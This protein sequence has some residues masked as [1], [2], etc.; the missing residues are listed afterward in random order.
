MNASEVLVSVLMTAYNREKYI[1]EAIL[2]V[3]NSTYANFELIIL[4]DCSIDRT[5][6]I[7]QEYQTRDPRI[8]VYSNQQNLGDYPN[9]NKA[10]SYAKG[11][12]IMFVDSDDSIHMK[13]IEYIVKAFEKYPSAQHST[14]YYEKDIFEVCL[15]NPKEA[16]TRH[17]YTNNMLAGGPGAKVFKKTFYSSMGGYPEQYGPANDMYFNIKTTSN[18]AILLLPFIYLNY[19]IHDAQESN[20]RLSYLVNGYNYFVDALKLPELP[21]NDKEKNYFNLKSKRRFLVNSLKYYFST[22]RFNKLRIAFKLTRFT[23][24]DFIKAVFQ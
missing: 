7:A 14:I 23:F 13:A 4:D 18:S 5:L 8:K 16:I 12:L 22:F 6:E 9:R 24:N 21:L 1:E 19:R 15:M 17:L 11:D 3:A 2:S 20:N 10:A